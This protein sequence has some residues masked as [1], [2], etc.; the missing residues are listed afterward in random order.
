MK[1]FIFIIILFFNISIFNA[2]AQITTNNKDEFG[3]K[4]GFWKYDLG[5]NE[6][7]TQNY[8]NDTLHGMS[9]ISINGNLIYKQFYLYGQKDSIWFTYYETG[10]LKEKKQFDKGKRK[11]IWLEFFITGTLKSK[12][13]YFN[14]TLTNNDISYN[15]KKNGIILEFYKTGELKYESFYLND[16]LINNKISYYINGNILR[17][18]NENSLETT[19]YLSGNIQTIYSYPK[20]RFGDLS[21]ILV[22]R[23]NGDTILPGHIR[24]IKHQTINSH[25]TIFGIKNSTNK[26]IELL[27]NQYDWDKKNNQDF[28]FFGFDLFNGAKV[29]VRDTLLFLYFPTSKILIA[30]SPNNTTLSYNLGDNLGDEIEVVKYQ[31][32]DRCAKA[33]SNLEYQKSTYKVRENFKNC[34][35]IIHRN[36]NGCGDT[37]TNP[38]DLYFKRKKIKFT[39]IDNVQIIEYD[40]DKNGENEIYIIS[41]VS[42][43]HLVKIF[44]IS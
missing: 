1:F 43:C 3:L 17:I 15:N 5:N 23:E 33:N 8:L 29:L 35:A 12:C 31:I 11:G 6:I 26:K 16:T 20:N 2:V 34:H 39:K 36:Q 38:I 24:N 44:K 37:G 40:L 21:P 4:Q 19:F 10:I 22:L 13:F 14:D 7:L 32:N 9:K 25:D 28:I 42:C 27:F 30:I 41:Y 18:S